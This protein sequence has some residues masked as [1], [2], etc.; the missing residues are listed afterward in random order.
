MYQSLNLTPF[1]QRICRDKTSEKL[2]VE[3][4]FR[5]GLQHVLRPQHSEAVCL[6]FFERTRQQ[7]NEQYKFIGKLD[8]DQYR[9]V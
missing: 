9:Y 5:G 4:E 6:R 1:R 8:L 2:R 3:V 7:G